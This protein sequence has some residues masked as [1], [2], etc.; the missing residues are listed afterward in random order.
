MILTRKEWESF[1]NKTR[2]EKAV[3][4]TA[5]EEVL[6]LYRKAHPPAFPKPTVY[7]LDAHEKGMRARFRETFER[8]RLIAQSSWKPLSPLTLSQALGISQ[9]AVSCTMDSTSG[10]GRIPDELMVDIHLKQMIPGFDL[11]Y[12]HP[13]FYEKIMLMVAQECECGA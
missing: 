8:G 12:V 5:T 10:H 11:A 7:T 2:E 13:A 6:R 3:P 9:V 4:P 1:R